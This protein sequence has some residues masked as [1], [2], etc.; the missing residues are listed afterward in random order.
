MVVIIIIAVVTNVIIFAIV[1][2]VVIIIITVVVATNI[3]RRQQVLHSNKVIQTDRMLAR[4]TTCTPR[5]PGTTLSK[6]VLV[7]FYVNRDYETGPTIYSPY[8]SRLDSQTIFRC[9]Y[10]Q[11]LFSPH[12]VLD[13]CHPARRSAA[14]RT[15]PTGQRFVLECTG[16][17]SYLSGVLK[18]KF[19]SQ[20]PVFCTFPG[21][22]RC[23]FPRSFCFA[24]K[25]CKAKW[26]LR[27]CWLKLCTSSGFFAF[28][29]QNVLPS[30]II[31]S[32]SWHRGKRKVLSRPSWILLSAGSKN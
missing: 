21:H 25:T 9:N 16:F 26:P 14:Q 10:K 19:P 11:P 30:S 29:P 27:I 17:L 13:L 5:T 3:T 18:R 12:W 15:E 32:R 1:T 24:E 23:E 20:R 2:V 8:P 4:T 7:I 28:P 6:T 31:L 22:Q